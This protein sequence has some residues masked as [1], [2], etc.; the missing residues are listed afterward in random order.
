MPVDVRVVPCLQDNYA[1]ILHEAATGTV[2][3]VD[4]PEVDA[5]VAALDTEG[6]RATHI[7]VTHKHEDHVAGV[8]ALKKTYGAIVIA[9]P[10]ADYIGVV[11]RIVTDGDTVE[12]GGL[13]AKVIAT[14][15][16]TNGH[17][18]YWFA[19]E[20]LLF[21]GDTMF[22][23][24]CGRVLEGKPPALWDSLKKLRALPPETQM[25]CGHEYTQSNAR[26]SRAIDPD[27]AALAARAEAI[28]AARAA[29][30]PTIPSTLAEELATNPFLRADM[31]VIAAAVGMAGRDAAAVFT[32]LRERKNR[33]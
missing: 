4:A 20:A 26:F 2:V 28:D 31:P 33:G 17:I 21:A 24:G 6:W 15:G 1:V 9:P 7:I 3:V 23:L 11:D 19:D 12:L 14:P 27:N 25:F 10:E 18:S 29:G 8:P 13:T 32:E 16:H 5:I 30:K 22:A